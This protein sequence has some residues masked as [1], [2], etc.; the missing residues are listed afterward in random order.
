MRVILIILFR[1][2]ILR[3]I[4]VDII[5]NI[6]HRIAKFMRK[7][8]HIRMSIPSYLSCPY[9]HQSYLFLLEYIQIHLSKQFLFPQH[10]SLLQEPGVGA[11]GDPSLIYFV[12]DIL[13]ISH[14]RHCHN[15]PHQ[16]NGSK[17][18]SKLYFFCVCFVL[19]YSFF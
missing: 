13:G 3:D 19:N 18:S 7:L 8:L 6:Y 2:Y 15:I 16:G 4:L 17:R 5:F 11:A 10:V 9:K 14:Y 12:S 1:Y